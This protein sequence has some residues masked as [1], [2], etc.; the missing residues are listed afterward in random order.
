MSTAMPPP[1]DVPRLG[2]KRVKSSS[3]LKAIIGDKT[4]KRTPS[5][6]AALSSN[7]PLRAQR[8]HDA[9]SSSNA[10]IL[11]ADHPHNQSRVLGELPVNNNAAVSPR[12]SR[13]AGDGSSR[14]AHKKTLSSVSLRSLGREKDNAGQ[15]RSPKK[16][17]REQDR[18]ELSPTKPKKT[19]S[20]TN[21]AATFL[22]S[23]SSKTI[24]TSMAPKDKEN[25]TPPS[26]AGGDGGAPIWAEYSSQKYQE[27]SKTTT[28]P[29]NDRDEVSS[30]K[31]YNAPSNR[32]PAKQRIL[33][34]R[35]TLQKRHQSDQRP[36]STPAWGL[37]SV[38][39]AGPAS[40]PLSAGRTLEQNSRV[41]QKQNMIIASSEAD[42]ATRVKAAVA[43][44]NSR[45]QEAAVDG[46]DPKGIEAAFEAVLVGILV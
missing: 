40:R 41:S 44:F 34:E 19:K 27:K 35:P 3:V 2:H 15:E 1:A 39:V 36:K 18:S 8:D 22:R 29:L 20:T 9:T 42:K 26:S 6:G 21:L 37:D 45:A 30:G 32:S 33:E 7:Q 16:S 14:P 10:C 4:H 12:K 25:T 23:R 38:S 24:D 31:D 46:L 11:P 17:T 28:V 5:E 13:D 43:E